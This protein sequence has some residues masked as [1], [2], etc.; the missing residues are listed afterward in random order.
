MLIP[1]WHN[2]T[3]CFFCLVFLSALSQVSS[4]SHLIDVEIRAKPLNCNSRTYEV[5]VI[6]YVKIGGVAFGGEDAF[7]AFGDGD[8]VLVPELAETELVDPILNIGKVQFT[9]IHTYETYGVYILSYFERNRNEGIVNMDGSV[10]TPFY[11]ES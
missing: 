9:V 3:L 11:T 1:K 4:A 5:T 8:S 7:V 10:T 2:K 6:A